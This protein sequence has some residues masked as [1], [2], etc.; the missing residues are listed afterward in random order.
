MLHFQCAHGCESRTLSL[1]FYSLFAA[2][3][4][5]PGTHTMANKSSKKSDYSD[6]WRKQIDD[7]DSI[8]LIRSDK[9]YIVYL[10]KGYD[11]EWLTTPEYDQH[12]AEDQQQHNAIYSEAAALECAPCHGLSNGIRKQYKR[13]IGEALT[14]NFED[15][16]DAARRM[17]EEAKAYIRARSE[18]ISRYW[19]LSASSIMA[20]V[21]IVIGALI[22]I[23]RE[24]ISAYL[25]A[26]FIWLCLAAAAG[27]SGAWLSVIGRSGQLKF[28]CSA[29]AALHYLEGASRIWA[30]ALSGVLVALAVKSGFVLAPL[31]RNGDSLIVVMVAAFAAGAGERLATS[32]VST[33][34]STHVAAGRSRNRRGDQAGG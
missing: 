3:T 27:S 13:L 25:T 16:Y 12:G 5:K 34:D 9:E 14:F 29:G 6:F 18:E 32:I 30:G 4:C 7:F 17:L 33:F 20:A 28:D 11:I 21:M 22:W 2:K 19:Y 24:P 15:D 1:K 26:D 31:S 23:F 10:D 8:Y